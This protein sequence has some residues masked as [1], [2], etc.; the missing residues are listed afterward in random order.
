MI[1]SRG[2]LQIAL[3]QYR[4]S[5]SAEQSFIPLFLS[6]LESDASFQ[7][8]HI[9]G[10]ITGSAWI[11]DRNREY[12]LLTH[13]AKL[14]KWLQPGGHAD[15]DEHVLRVALREAEEETGVKNFSILH[16]GIFDIDIHPIPERKDMVAHDHYDI[17]FLVEAD[18]LEP[19]IITEESHDLA[20]IKIKELANYN[21]SPSL[22]RMAEKVKRLF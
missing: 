15:G 8:T 3:Q 1:D 14:N 11:V 21:D 19:L 12:V 2:K 4:T 16:E 9:P 10:H 18:R 13:H 22:G 7:R 20:W 17:R 6:L 5:Y